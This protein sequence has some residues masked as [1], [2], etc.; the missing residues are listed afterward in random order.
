LR[1]ADLAE[2]QL[3]FFTK[4]IKF[5][6]GEKQM[7][8]R[9]GSSSQRERDKTVQGKI[10]RDKER[11]RKLKRLLPSDY[12]IEV[13]SRS[14]QIAKINPSKLPRKPVNILLLC[15]EGKETSP[16]VKRFYEK[17]LEHQMLSGRFRLAANGAAVLSPDELEAI[18]G[19]SDFVVF[20]YADLSK[21]TYVKP[22]IDKIAA[23]SVRPIF[24]EISVPKPN[25]RKTRAHQSLLQTLAGATSTFNYIA[26]QINQGALKKKRAI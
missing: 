20:T 5:G 4:A 12:F 11:L 15:Y 8:K 1:K 18:M 25:L 6:K 26:E 16:F 2:K 21:T 19:E 3:Y 14:K 17:I 22:I 7:E 10:P 24:T 13:F 9:P 23:S